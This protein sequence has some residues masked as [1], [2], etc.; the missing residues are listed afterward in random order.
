[1]FGILPTAL[2]AAASPGASPPLPT[3]G[4][5]NVDYAASSCV[6]SRVYANGERT[7][8]LA[9]RPSPIAGTMQIIVVRDDRSN[10][11]A[12]QHGATIGDASGTVIRASQLD[13][14]V[15]GKPPKSV[16]LVT[17]TD[18]QFAT[19]GG[20]DEWRLR[21]EV[22]RPVR[23]A[24]RQLVEV[25]AELGNC[26][27]DL[28]TYWN[29]APITVV[30]LKSQARPMQPLGRYFS[31]FDYP[32]QAMREHNTGLVAVR[33][34]ID[35][36]GKIADCATM[37][38]SGSAILDAMSCIVLRERARYTPAMGLDGTPMRSFAD[39]CINWK[40]P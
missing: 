17:L 27:A 14:A 39:S 21:G 29:M 38:T 2:L 23:L 22:G 12:N 34:M 28:T 31:P 33:L 16:S 11:S 30:G 40:L 10:V 3:A 9:L 32:Q 7:L 1:M 35:A 5:W 13:Y 25:K 18:A 6:A 15:P 8:T 36:S 4:P 37:Q 26:L 20:Q 24:M 19:L